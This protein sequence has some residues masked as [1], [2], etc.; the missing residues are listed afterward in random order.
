[1]R[2]YFVREYT[3]SLLKGESLRANINHTAGFSHDNTFAFQH[4]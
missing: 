1:M 4:Y 3:I 2:M